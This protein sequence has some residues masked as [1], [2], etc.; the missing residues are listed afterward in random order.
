MLNYSFQ[1]RK[2]GINTPNS[3]Y[4]LKQNLHL[5]WYKDKKITIRILKNQ[6]YRNFLFFNHL[7]HTNFH[8]LMIANFIQELILMNKNLNGSEFVHKE[9]IKEKKLTQIFS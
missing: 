6:F 3:I 1:R 2:K 4:N 7:F 5:L 8:K 9:L